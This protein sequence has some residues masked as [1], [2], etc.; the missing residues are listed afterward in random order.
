MTCIQKS[1]KISNVQFDELSQSQYSQAANRGDR[2]LPALPGPGAPSPQR[3]PLAPRRKS[4]RWLFGL[5]VK[6]LTFSTLAYRDSNLAVFLDQRLRSCGPCVGGIAEPGV[7]C[8]EVGATPRGAQGTDRARVFHKDPVCIKTWP[9]TVNCRIPGAGRGADRE[10][11]QSGPERRR[12]RAWSSRGKAP[13]RPRAVRAVTVPP[14][15]RAQD[16][17]PP[18]PLHLPSASLSDPFLGVPSSSLPQTR[19]SVFEVP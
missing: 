15:A 2:R 5:S 3:R 16:R 12:P 17:A 8:V 14:Q 4:R 19:T 1:T 6:G 9:K 13:G 18:P 11:P 10:G 7:M